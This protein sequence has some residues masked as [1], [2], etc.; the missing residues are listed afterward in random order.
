MNPLSQPSELSTPDSSGVEFG[1]SADGLSV[2][3][4][5]DLV[6]AMV[7]A[8]NGRYFLA[9]AWRMTRPLS[10]LK[11]D[12]FYSHHGSVANEAAF[13]GRMVEQAEH[14]RELRALARQSVRM[15]CSTP[16]GASQGATVYADGIVSH[17][18]AGHGGFKLSAV[19]DAAV[20]P[21]LQ[22]GGG[23]YEEDA[24]WAIVALT[25]PD[26]FTR[27]ER[28]CADKTVRDSWPDAWEA[29]YGRSLLPGESCERDS[30]AF[31]QV[32][33]GDWIVIA[34]LR[35]DHHPG[36]TEAIA[37]IGGKRDERAEERRFLVPSSDYAV[38][39]F[40]FVIDETKH[41]AYD[42]PSSFASWRRR[43]A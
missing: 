13:Q 22:A 17:T 15:N 2:A 14:F 42:G 23:W 24:A 26:L 3:R 29:I 37:T 4:I 36:M 31:A 25:F 40:G 18:T 27:Y 6:F 43:A 34:A 16:W 30:Q 41:A 1:R 7:P 19:R 9:S 21:M 38:G 20:H 35:S 33:A 5:G 28:K 12:D 11:R 10:D 8:R 39:R 32:H